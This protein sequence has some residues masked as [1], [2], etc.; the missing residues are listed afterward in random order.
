MMTAISSPTISHHILSW[1]SNFSVN[2][3]IGVIKWFKYT[4]DVSIIDV[5]AP[6][7]AKVIIIFRDLA[8]RPPNNKPRLQEQAMLTR[9]PALMR[10]RTNLMITYDP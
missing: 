10:T 2:A 7:P 1:H 3:G 4:I 9:R 6:Q 5:G 8:A